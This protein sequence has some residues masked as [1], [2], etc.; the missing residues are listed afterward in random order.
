MLYSPPERRLL[1]SIRKIG[2]RGG[3]REGIQRPVLRGENIRDRSLTLSSSPTNC[4]P[5]AVDSAASSPAPPTGSPSAAR[6]GP[7]PCQDAEVLPGTDPSACS[8]IP[9]PFVRLRG[10]LRPPRL[11]VDGLTCMS[12]E[13]TS[14]G[15]E[16]PLEGPGGS[17]YMTAKNI[18]HLSSVPHGP[19]VSYASM[20][21]LI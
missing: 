3:G 5:G 11:G 20:H 2:G 16:S 15:H 10:I 14:L 17:N 1:I 12:A 13:P 8:A 21:R 4:P 6:A 18:D 19:R 7:A 9:S